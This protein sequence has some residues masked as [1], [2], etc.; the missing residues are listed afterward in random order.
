M[1][2][3]IPLYSNTTYIRYGKSHLLSDTISS[4]S[5]C[6]RR[7]FRSFRVN[8]SKTSIYC[9]SVSTSI[10]YCKC[11]SGIRVGISQINK[12]IIIGLRWMS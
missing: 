9:P 2:R 10:C 7:Y 8:L 5:S 11:I 12:E 1:I 4:V 3:T 6:L